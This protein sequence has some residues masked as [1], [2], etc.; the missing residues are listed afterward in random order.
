MDVYRVARLGAPLDAVV[1]VPGSKSVANRALVCA[2]LAEGESVLRSVPDGDDSEAM[3]DCLRALGLE[4]E[5][6]AADVRLVGGVKAFRRGPITLHTRLAG[7]TSRFITAVAALGPGPYTIDGLAPLRQRPMAPLHDALVSMGVQVNPGDRWGHLPVTVHG[8]VDVTL[9]EVS[10]RGDVSSQYL[11]ALMLIAPYFP[12]G[13]RFML[14]TPLV[15]RPYIRITAAVMAAFGVPGVELGDRIITVPA[16]RYQA[17][18]YTIEP[19]ASSASYPLAAAAICGGKV[20]VPGLTAGS[21]QGDAAFCHV[22]GRMG[23]EVQQDQWG[24]T[25]NRTGELRGIE[26]NMVDLSDLVPTLAVVA[27]FASGPT[28]IHG[29]GFIRHKESDRLT[30]LCQ[31]LRKAGIDAVDNPDGLVVRPGTPHSATLGTHH[32]HRLAMAFAL[33]GLGASGI[34]VEDPD[35]VS[36]SWPDF[37]SMIESLR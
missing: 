24:T 12:D 27:A 22:L 20:R 11:T 4:V 28:D 8:P 5:R 35:V 9:D 32:D 34:I 19:D 18:E 3:L 31:E 30:D 29:V 6:A 17:R 37:W 36:K 15:S 16:G 33:V 10:L 7:T 2:A 23:C 14:T 1:D 13:L 26:I 25:V 21:L